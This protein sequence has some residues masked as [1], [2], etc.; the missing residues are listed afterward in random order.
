MHY[1]C[2][3]YLIYFS[4]FP[5]QTTSWRIHRYPLSTDMETWTPDLG[6]EHL[7]KEPTLLSMML[8]PNGVAE[9]GP[10]LCSL[11]PRDRC[12]HS[13]GAKLLAWSSKHITTWKT[14]PPDPIHQVNFG[15]QK[16]KIKGAPMSPKRV[17]SSCIGGKNKER[18]SSYFE[19]L[20][21]QHT[22]AGQG[23]EPS[24]MP[25]LLETEKWMNDPWQSCPVWGQY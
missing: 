7:C 18:S 4:C 9:Q 11:T 6:C 8:C 25:S 2:P 19:G 23:S 22:S 15:F 16:G 3:K 24:R 10:G 12:V 17:Q 13:G 14:F 5:L 1:Y 20:D 21:R